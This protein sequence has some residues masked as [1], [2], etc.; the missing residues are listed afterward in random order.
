M[1]Y[2]GTID[3]II[4]AVYFLFLLLVGLYLKNKAAESLD[5]YFLGGRKMPWWALGF[6]GM[7]YYVNISGTL[8]IISF[9][10]MLGPRG[11][12]IEFRGGACLVMVFMLLWTGKWHRRSGCMTLAEWMK[13][14]F[15][16]GMGAQFSRL[17]QVFAVVTLSVGMLAL[18]VKALGIFLATF[19]PLSP[20]LC[21]LIF[22][23]IAAAYTTMSGFYGVVVTDIIQGVMVL[24]GAVICGVLAFNKYPDVS[25][26]AET[27]A[28]VTGN[29]NW[30]SSLPGTDVNLPAGYEQYSNLLSF[31][32]SYLFLNILLGMGISGA[33]PIYFGARNDRECGTLSFLWVFTM[34]ARWILIMA[35]AVFGVFMIKE[36]FP[37]QSVLAESAALIKQHMPEVEPSQWNNLLSGIANAPQAYAPEMTAGLERLLEDNWAQKLKMLSYEGTVNPE[38]IMSTVLGSRIP[39]GISGIILICLIAAAMSTIDITINKAAGF[40]VKDVYQAYLRRDAKNKELISASYVFTLALVGAGFAMAYSVKN[41]NQIWGWMVMSLNAGLVAP[42][43]LRL[44]WWRFSGAAFAIGTGFGIGL[45]ILQWHFYPDMD[46]RLSMVTLLGGTVL[47]TI[48]VSFIFRPAPDDVLEKFYRRTKPFGLWGPLKKRLDPETLRRMN[49]E[50]RNDILAVPFVLGWQVTMFLMAM[51]VV[52]HA[53]KSFAVTL[54]IS[55]VCVTGMYF[56]WYRHLP[57]ENYWPEDEAGGEVSVS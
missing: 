20:W 12:Y 26:L 43:L 21:S 47:V 56:F 22:V 30:T 48:I 37:D 3:W 53:W 33:E 55:A 2:I 46:E 8:L 17:F 27:A 41:V 1:Y 40:F 44:Y 34:T 35:F 49:K 23:G 51:Q 24:A 50:H 11:L 13:F 10:Y 42:A 16:T 18:T 31:A 45:S 6:T 29:M 14:R 36:F 9:I 38:M 25:V 15:G 5:D 19:V 4:V 54:A 7:G 52:M 32:V 39:T 57:K 28:E